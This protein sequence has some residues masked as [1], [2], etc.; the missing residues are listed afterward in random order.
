M[1]CCFKFGPEH[2]RA[3]RA[4]LP[5]RL[6][7]PVRIVVLASLAASSTYILLHLRTLSALVVPGL[8]L[9][10]VVAARALTECRRSVHAHRHWQ[11]LERRLEEEEEER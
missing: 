3:L 4:Q 9:H 6:V 11:E 10:L 1:G 8:L 2:N 7:L 5:Y